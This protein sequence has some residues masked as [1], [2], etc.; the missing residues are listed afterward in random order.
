MCAFEL[1]LITAEP[2]IYVR[3]TIDDTDKV[4]QGRRQRQVKQRHLV[5]Y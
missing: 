1:S 5:L 4:K 2:P 3:M